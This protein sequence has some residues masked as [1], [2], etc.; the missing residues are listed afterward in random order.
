MKNRGTLAGLVG[1]LLAVGVLVMV[2]G[3]PPVIPDVGCVDNVDCDDGTF[4]NGDETCVDGACVAGDPPCD[5]DMQRCDEDDDICIDFCETNED[6]DDDDLCTT[7]A[8]AEG[9]CL[10]TLVECEDDGLFCTGED[11]C[12]S[13]TGECVSSGEPC[14]DDGLLCD[15]G[16][17]ACVECLVDADCA[18]GETCVEGTCVADAGGCVTDADCADGETCVDGECVADAG[19]DGAALYATNCAG[20]HGVEGQGGAGP[21]IRLYTAAQLTTGLESVI[22]AGFALT[23]EQ[24][25]AMADYLGG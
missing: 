12:D 3:C 23:E 20:C 1:G 19:P 15:E 17:D 9:E 25:A 21:D 13:D 11:V 6:C 14:E 8:C 16:N 22:H 10:Y 24:V 7:D 2:G 18:E 4:C 5:L